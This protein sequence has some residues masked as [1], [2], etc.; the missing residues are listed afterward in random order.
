MMASNNDFRRTSAFT[1]RYNEFRNHFIKFAS[2]YAKQ[3]KVTNELLEC[4]V[5]RSHMTCFKMNYFASLPQIQRTHEFM[6]Y[7]KMSCYLEKV[8]AFVYA[9]VQTGQRELAEFTDGDMY[10]DYAR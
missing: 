3:L 10:R 4:M 6:S 9:L 2:H 7:M 5:E 1:N 8:D